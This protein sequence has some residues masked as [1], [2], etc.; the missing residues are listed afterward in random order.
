MAMSKYD[1]A[2]HSVSRR[3]FTVRPVTNPVPLNGAMPPLPVRFSIANASPCGRGRKK[4][5][6]D[7]TTPYAER[8][9][10]T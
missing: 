7:P 6:K 5:I 3:A 4:T 8:G 1:G 9:E 2:D 10:T